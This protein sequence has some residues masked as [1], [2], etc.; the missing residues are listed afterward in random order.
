MRYCVLFAVWSLL[1]GSAAHAQSYG[2]GFHS[3]EVVPEKRTSLNLTP[4]T[5]LCLRQQTDISFD[6]NFVPY[7]DTYFGYVLRLIFTNGQNIDLVYNQ[8][9]GNF[10]FLI[11]EG[12]S[13]VFRIDSATLYNGWAHCRIRI[14]PRRQEAA[15]YLNDTLVA[16]GRGHFGKEVCC[17]LFFGAN[18]FEGFQML[19]IPP[20]NIK[21]IAIREG[22]RLKYYWPLSESAGNDGKDTVRGKLAEVKNPGWIRPQHLQWQLQ[23]ALKLKGVPSVAFDE[24]KE[25]LYIV[26]SDSLYRLA[27]RHMQLSAVGLSEKH[28]TLLPGNQSIYDPFRQQLYNFYID[29]QRV[30]VYDTLAQKWSAGFIPA[31][32]TEYWHANKFISNYDTSL[33][34]LG[35]YGQLEYKNKVQRCHLPDQRWDAVPTAG[36]RFMPRYLAALG[37]NAAGD[38]AYILGGYGSSTGSQVVSPKYYYD[39]LAFSVKDHS[40]R[41]LYRL[42]EPERQFC[43][44][45][46]LVINEAAQEYY[47]LVYPNDQFNSELQL[48][49]G[50]LRLP[51]YSLLGAPLPYAYHDVQSFADLYYCAGS[52]K[53]VAIT[54]YTSKENIADVKV[55]TIAFPPNMLA[56][57]VPP[58]NS[59][60][61][62]Y[63]ALAAAVLALLGYL[64]RRK[65]IRGGKAVVQSPPAEQPLPEAEP[66]TEPERQAT[67]YLFGQFEVYDKAGNDITGAFTPLLKELFLILAIH[68]LRSGKGIS[69]E[70]LYAALWRD[71]SSKE[72]QNNRSVNMVKLKAILDRLG[73]CSFVKDADRWSFQYNRE[74]INID[75]A[76][77]LQW[78]RPAA[79]LNKE[80]VQGFLKIIRRGALLADTA[81]P[82]LEDIQSEISSTAL[83]ILSAATVQFS[84]DP[85]FLIEIANGIFIFDPVNEEALRVKCKSLGQLGRHSMA[86]AIFTRFTREYYEMYGEDFQGTFH[87][88]FH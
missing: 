45:N 5:P 68:T 31:P 22:N 34:I 71:K 8:K 3:H 76:G 21:D 55:Y 33:Y 72:A 16:K 32:L 19:D 78:G 54:I 73:T 50:S 48:I 75:L 10:D 7:H 84:G 40:F 39:L 61:W 4:E 77:F 13:E 60:R 26:S 35:G 69:A 85:A 6:L 18:N 66:V 42:P 28:D 1:L 58:E 14:D 74:R 11:G 30:S 24:K 57:A 51:Q 23:S 53:L 59:R 56:D 79:I 49:R 29:Q 44:A 36:D 17:R 12:Y 27:F 82:W 88:V 64:L 41:T 62:Y 20:M 9:T 47:A 83:S 46:S 86:K 25:M 43:F 37:A 70:K 63:L 87:E 67:V 52:K 15:F 80:A 38:T 81:Y 65:S 2:L